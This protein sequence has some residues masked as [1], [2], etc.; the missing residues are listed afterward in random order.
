MAKAA[1]SEIYY[2]TGAMPLSLTLPA[3]LRQVYVH[4]LTASSKPRA[5]QAR[6][7]QL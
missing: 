3:A 7:R 2:F 6:L 5:F 4:A 1:V